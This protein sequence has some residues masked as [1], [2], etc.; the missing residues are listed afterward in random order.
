MTLLLVLVTGCWDFDPIDG[1]GG[2]VRPPNDP[3][4]PPD[5]P[6]D[7]P[8][9]PCGEFRCSPKTP[10]GVGFEGIKPVRNEFPNGAWSGINNHI[11]VG[12]LHEVTLKNGTTDQDFTLLY[13]A[14]SDDLTK[15]GIEEVDGPN[16]TLR[17][18]GGT[19]YLR[20]IDPETG[21]LYDRGAYA[22]SRFL[23]AL[24]VGL[25][26]A[27]TTTDL[28]DSAAA[29]KFAPGHRVIGVAYL[30]SFGPPNRLVDTA[31][32]ITMAGATQVGWDR[33]DIMLATVG[34]HDVM[35]EV[36][37]T[38][39]TME[40]EVTSTADVVTQLLY[41]GNIACFGAFDDGAFIAGL[42]WTY[43]VDGVPVVS[44][45]FF[46]PNC[47]IN[48]T[49]AEQLVTARAGGKSLTIPVPP[50]TEQQARAQLAEVMSQRQAA[51]AVDAPVLD[52][53]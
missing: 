53:N 22:S 52:A 21:E 38:A 10:D 26:E 51:F 3:D 16:L 11:A 12:G 46:G 13:R 30:N 15:L 18:L 29:F 14:E 5:D 35:V 40:I 42:P 25:D 34:T 2:V 50:G 45:T 33:L 6:D 4:Y 20:L 7:P 23:R 8:V 28:F 24:P 27:F 49:P 32:K 31:A 37:G 47:Y 44:D 19:A 48:T 43:S 1:D 36:G 41:F 9:G 17:G 39:A